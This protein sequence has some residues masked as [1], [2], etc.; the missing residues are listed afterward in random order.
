MPGVLQE[1]DQR[2]RIMLGEVV[3]DLG[4]AAQFHGGRQ[5][6]QRVD[7]EAALEMRGQLP[8]DARDRLVKGF[9]ARHVGEQQGLGAEVAGQ[10]REGRHLR[11]AGVEMKHRLVVAVQVQ[12]ELG[13]HR[14][15][16]Q[17]ALEGLGFAGRLPG[18]QQAGA[19]RADDARIGLG[20]VAELRLDDRDQGGRQVLEMPV[21]I[22]AGG[23]VEATAGRALQVLGQADGVGHR[24]QHDLAVDGACRVQ[25]LQPLAQRLGD[26]HGRDLVGMQGGLQIGLVARCAAAEV[27]AAQPACRAGA[28]AG[29]FV[30]LGSHGDGAV[31]PR[32]VRAPGS[33]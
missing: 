7:R 26:E 27:Q 23:Q 29:Q 33:A 32:G 25:Q 28:G 15:P 2:V 30:D 6:A 8:P 9:V 19:G 21:E 22:G 4:F 3:R 17:Q 10:R 11:R 13:V 31:Q 24:H 20:V 18:V 14:Q 16:L 1:G 5:A 12:H